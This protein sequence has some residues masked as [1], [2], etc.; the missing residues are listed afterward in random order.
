MHLL[1]LASTY[2]RLLLVEM[3]CKTG[4]FQL[5]NS[6]NPCLAGKPPCLDWQKTILKRKDRG[7]IVSS[8]L[9]VWL[10]TQE[11][12]KCTPLPNVKLFEK[13]GVQNAGKP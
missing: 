9:M 12:I 1:L 2:F 7:Q 8:V 5:Q 10:I 4:C 13:G 6:Y 3:F 11:M